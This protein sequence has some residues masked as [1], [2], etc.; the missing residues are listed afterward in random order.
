MIYFAQE[1]SEH[2]R[3]NRIYNIYLPDILPPSVGC[4]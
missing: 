1:L 3:G 2:D 4:A